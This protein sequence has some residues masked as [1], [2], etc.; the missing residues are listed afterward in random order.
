M[1]IN[2]TPFKIRFTRTFRGDFF[3][4]NWIDFQ[5]DK[6]INK[7]LFRSTLTKLDWYSVCKIN[8][9]RADQTRF[10]NTPD[11][12]GT[13][14]TIKST[15]VSLKYNLMIVFFDPYFIWLTLKVELPY[16]ISTC[17]IYCIGLASAHLIQLFVKIW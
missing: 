17:L 4:F 12:F 8:T 11:L 10:S 3:R 1:S 6:S 7:G 5:I 9:Y 15:L 16:V 2:K 13:N 14:I